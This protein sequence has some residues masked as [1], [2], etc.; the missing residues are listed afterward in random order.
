MKATLKK[1]NLNLHELEQQIGCLDLQWK[2]FNS[3]AFASNDLQM[4][5]DIK[6]LTGINGLG[7][8]RKK[9]EYNSIVVTLYGFF[10]QFIEEIIVAYLRALNELVPQYN[11]LPEN[12]KKNH[13]EATTVLLSKP[14]LQKFRDFIKVEELIG[15]LHSCI[16]NTSAYRLNAYAFTYHTA[17]FKVDVIDQAFAKIGVQ[18]LSKRIQNTRD[19]IDHLTNVDPDR[20][21][22]SNASAGEFFYEIN[23][24]AER[25]NEVAHGSPCEILSNSFLIEYLKFIQKY[26]ESICSILL[27]EYLTQEIKLSRN[28]GIPIAGYN[29]KIVCFNLNQSSVAIGDRIF[30]ETTDSQIKCMEG[31]I[32]SIQVDDISYQTYCCQTP[33]NIG[34]KVDFKAKST[35]SYYLAEPASTPWE[36]DK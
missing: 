28:I 7:V 20:L 13:V 26:A 16:S 11:L 1:F 5:K 18:N 17:N 25:R 4:E 12:I 31:T 35:Y 8:F 3:P 2:I 19:L 6:L 34:L 14:D 15:N 21:R 36:V 29:N 27:M 32:I 30:A 10:E 23:D 22:V 33:I 9:F 24:L